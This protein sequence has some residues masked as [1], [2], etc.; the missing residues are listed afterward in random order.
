MS[1][2]I[3]APEINIFIDPSQSL[4]TAH[5]SSPVE[6]IFHQHL[7]AAPAEAEQSGSAEHF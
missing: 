7:V 4:V 6:A 2:A 1:P 3:P 5:A